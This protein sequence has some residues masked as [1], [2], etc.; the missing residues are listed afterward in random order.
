[1]E[2]I[3]IRFCIEKIFI[4]AL[5]CCNNEHRK[6]FN[7]MGNVISLTARYLWYRLSF[8]SRVL[9]WVSGVVEQ[10]EGAAGE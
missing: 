3:I 4:V 2:L 10:R 1:V 8:I 6:G 7:K 9:F 5:S